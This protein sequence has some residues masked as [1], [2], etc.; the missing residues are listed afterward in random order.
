MQFIPQELSLAYQEYDR[1]I[2]IANKVG[3][4]AGHRA[5]A[6]LWSFGFLCLQ[7]LAPKFFLLRL[8][9]SA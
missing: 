7:A 5:G 4:L 2:I 6:G 9:C 3:L 1:E 8:L